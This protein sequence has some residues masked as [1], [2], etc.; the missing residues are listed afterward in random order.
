MASRRYDPQASRADI[1]DAAERLFAEH[2]FGDVSTSRIAK[3]AGVSQSQIHYHFD[4]KRKLWAAVFQRRFGDYF[5]R[6]AEMLA[7]TEL[8]GLDRLGAS[9]RAYFDF[10]RENPLFIKLLG[11]AQ[12]DSRGERDEESMAPELMR[13]G[14]EVIARGQREGRLRNDVPPQ[15]IL[16]GFLSLVAF[17]FQ[18]RDQYV[19]QTGL[20][21]P[22][23][24]HDD[25]YLDF[26]LKT[27]LR[28][29]APG[30]E[31]GGS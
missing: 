3:K 20:E 17:W 29:V 6:Q 10:F 11:R 23:E 21:G 24:S 13:Q 9:I 22:P 26:I 19:P 8:E 1:L 14:V 30:K 2:G 27:Y 4:T 25:A 18:A 5:E 16:I 7:G 31:H 12:L 15:F 28:G